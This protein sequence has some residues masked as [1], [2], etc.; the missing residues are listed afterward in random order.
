MS[1]ERNTAWPLPNGGRDD[2]SANALTAPATDRVVY[3]GQCSDGRRYI[4][5]MASKTLAQA[6]D[7]SGASWRLPHGSG[8]G[9]RIGPFDLDVVGQRVNGFHLPMTVV[10]ESGAR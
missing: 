6:L 2:I 1:H 10:W 8:A 5:T 4:A 7:A 3:H 9:W